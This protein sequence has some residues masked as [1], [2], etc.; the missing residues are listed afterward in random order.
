[1]EI[2]VLGIEQGEFA[3]QL[4]HIER[5]QKAQQLG[6]E[7]MSKAQALPRPEFEDFNYEQLKEIA[8]HKAK[9]LLSSHTMESQITPC[10]QIS[11]DVR[12]L[13]ELG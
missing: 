12:L 6:N 5:I 4:I 9:S 2:S 11:P 1:M 3:R 10:F 7:G 8:E 13:L